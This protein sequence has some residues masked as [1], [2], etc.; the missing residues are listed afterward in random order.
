M[1]AIN[2]ID[3]RVWAKNFIKAVKENPSIATDFGTVTGWFAYAIMA[4]Y[5]AGCKKAKEEEEL[6]VAKD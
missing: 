6:T 5:D 4:G 2:T 3:A 1:N